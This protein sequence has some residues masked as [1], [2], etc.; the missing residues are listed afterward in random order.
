M[1]HTGG[2]W[3][4]KSEF[5]QSRRRVTEV[6]E[7]KTMEGQARYSTMCFEM[8]TVLAV[9]GIQL[10]RSVALILTLQFQGH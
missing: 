10:V 3:V 5:D 9:E 8:G 2:T 7:W 6:R 4:I 1:N